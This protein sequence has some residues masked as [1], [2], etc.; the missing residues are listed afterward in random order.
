MI[1]PEPFVVMATQNPIEYEGTFL[2]PEAQ[3]DRFLIKVKV[4]Y[5]SFK[6][7]F[8]MLENRE[9]RQRDEFDLKKVSKP[10]ELLAAI[11]T[12]ETVYVSSQIASHV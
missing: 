4:G 8:V 11:K 5:P 9:E 1:L 12:I 7:E 6:D 2:L 10:K 3:I